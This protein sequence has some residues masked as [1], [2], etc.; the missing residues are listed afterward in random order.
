[1]VLLEFSMYPTDKGES[2]SPYVSRILNIIDESGIAYK[3]TPMGTV[4]EGEWDRVMQVVSACYKE[5]EKDC[6]RISVNLKVDYRK[7]SESRLTGKIEK[8]E[9]L[10]GKELKK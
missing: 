3:L 2:V 10:L 6:N 9:S 5:L 1:M 8:I 7:G 4:L